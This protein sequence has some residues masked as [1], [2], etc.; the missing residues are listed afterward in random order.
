MEKLQ[1]DVESPKMT[2]IGPETTILDIQIF[3]FQN[4]WN[5]RKNKKSV[6]DKTAAESLEI[7][8]H[9]ES[10]TQLK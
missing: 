3:F 1:F 10:L 4:F 5:T 8:M 6:M 2:T 7:P 9:K